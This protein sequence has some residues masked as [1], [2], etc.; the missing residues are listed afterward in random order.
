MI[1]HMDE[2]QLY[3][4]H[5]EFCKVLANPKRLEIM[6]LL[7]QEELCVE[8]ITEKMHIRVANV[9][10]HLSIMRK[11]GIV[12]TR[13]EGKNIYYRIANKKIIQACSIMREVMIENMKK[14]L[15]LLEDQN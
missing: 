4:H 5:A 2:K 11:K 7:G 13:R 9:S 3:K 12:N 1:L 15:K 14:D 10:Q 6:F 8:E